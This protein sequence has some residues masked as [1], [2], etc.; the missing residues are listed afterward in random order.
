M[1][2]PVTPT[3]S[4]QGD[5]PKPRAI[6][7]LGPGFTPERGVADFVTNQLPRSG[8]DFI[9]NTVHAVTHAPQ[10]AWDLGKLIAGGVRAGAREFGVDMGHNESDDTA[11]AFAHYVQNRYGSV[12]K[13]KESLY[14]DPVGVMSDF[15]AVATA[16]GG[17]TKLATLGKM[18]STALKAGEMAN[19]L[20]LPSKA[21]SGIIKLATPR[22]LP[23]GGFD[24]KTATF[25]PTGP[26][27]PPKAPAGP[28]PAAVKQRAYDLAGLPMDQDTFGAA[29]VPSPEQWR[30]A[31]QDVRGK[32]KP[33]AEAKPAPAAPA[34]QSSIKALLSG[35]GVTWALEHLSHHLL[36]AA[37]G[38]ALTAG[39]IKYLPDVLRSSAGQAILARLGPGSTAATAAAVARDLIPALNTMYKSQHQDQPF[40]MP[41]SLQPRLLQGSPYAKGGEVNRELARI[42]RE[43]LPLLGIHDVLRAKV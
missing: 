40:V 21:A 22:T 26:E 37:T 18:G 42:Q 28:D 12:D 14:T 1:N 32:M 23:E 35:A 7:D 9:T 5:E 29:K 17:I 31:D 20:F 15:S 43:R 8:L 11:Q 39:A 41:S 25:G 4:Q 19:P 2:Q 34:S 33:Q 27:A 30:Q 10:T 16:A 36:G 6:T 38:G 13:A 24:P 3:P